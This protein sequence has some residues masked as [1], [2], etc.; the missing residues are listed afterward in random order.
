GDVQRR[1][2]FDVPLMNAAVVGELSV[3]Q[4]GERH[5][6][7]HEYNHEHGDGAPHWILLL[8]AA[9]TSG[10]YAAPLSG[11]LQPGDRSESLSP[12][13]IRLAHSLMITIKSRR[14]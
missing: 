2:A 9:S 8:S 1:Q 14:E 7:H 11:R 5:H 6:C 10:T 4:R 13:R 12:A 3:R